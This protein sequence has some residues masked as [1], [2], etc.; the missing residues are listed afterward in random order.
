MLYPITS[1]LRFLLRSGN[2][3]GLHSPF[4]YDLYTKCIRDKMDYPIYEVMSNYRKALY[5]DHRA[6][7][8]TDLGAGS[9]VFKPNKAR[10]VWAIARN[11]GAGKK[12]QRLLFRLARYFKAKEILE[13]GTS[14]GLGTIALAL[15]D[16]KARVV[17]VEGCPNTARIAQYYF[18]R[19]SLRNISLV[20]KSFEAALKSRKE[21]VDLIYLDGQHSYTGTKELFEMILP[22]THNDS[23]LILDDIYWSQDIQKAWKEVSNDKRVRV[24]IDLYWM[25]LVFF[26]KEQPKQHFTLRL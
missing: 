18:D 2:A 12:K 24:S 26:R 4:V 3:H 22:L 5:Q 23:L 19:F 9:K 20:N 14:V 6:I 8:V 25:G 11:A 16:A 10:K 1:Y 13:L 7:E 21:P 15:A 17:T